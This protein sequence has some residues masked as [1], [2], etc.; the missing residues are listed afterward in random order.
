MGAAS[1]PCWSPQLLPAAACPCVTCPAANACRPLQLA[2]CGLHSCPMQCSSPCR[3]PAP[4]SAAASS[5]LQ[6]PCRRG[7]RGCSHAAA[8][9]PEPAPPLPMQAAPPLLASPRRCSLCKPP[10]NSQ[11][12]STARTRRSPRSAQLTS[13]PSLARPPPN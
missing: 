11:R 5:A 9:P 8:A 6:H 7:S 3:A 2:A 4:T 1:S 10:R 13:R 12:A